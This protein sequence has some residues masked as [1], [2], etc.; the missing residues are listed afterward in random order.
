MERPATYGLVHPV[1][2]SAEIKRGLKEIARRKS[3]TL[4]EVIREALREKI[5]KEK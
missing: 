3:L 1:R 2:M 4:A 5:K